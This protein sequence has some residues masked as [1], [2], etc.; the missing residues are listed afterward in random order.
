MVLLTD[1][2]EKKIVA[3]DGYGPK[4]VGTHHFRNRDA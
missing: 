4:I 2:P 1:M 3:L